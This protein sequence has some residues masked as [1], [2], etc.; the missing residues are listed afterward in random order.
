[1]STEILRAGKRLM[2]YVWDTPPKNEDEASI[3]CLGVE[4]DSHP[5][6]T[7]STATVQS[8]SYSDSAPSQV[9]SKL[10][11]TKDE[12]KTQDAILA[13]E[14]ESFEKVEAQDAGPDD[15]WPPAF[16]DD[17]ESKIWLTYRSDFPPIPKSTHPSAMTSM[18]WQTKLKMMAQQGGFNTDSGWG[19]MIRSG[20]SL[21]AN[22]LAM[23]ELGRGIVIIIII[24]III[25][26]STI[27]TIIITITI[28]STSEDDRS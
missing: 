25:I 26:T 16:L 17:F 18:S 21:L 24:L 14:D 9:D 2:Q 6:P 20:Q 1:M 3:W 10:S 19:C 5:V 15:G 23:L 8:P 22:T 4:Y 12:D 7:D 11:S 28:K 27:I 13:A